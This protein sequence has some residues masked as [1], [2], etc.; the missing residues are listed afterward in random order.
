[1]LTSFSRA[2]D[3]AHDGQVHEATRL[4]SQSLKEFER[5]EL[6]NLHQIQGIVL[7]TIMT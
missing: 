4:F 5:L 2:A 1:M 7:V 6:P 3:C